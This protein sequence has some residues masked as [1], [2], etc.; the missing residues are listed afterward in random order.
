MLAYAG[1]ISM[2]D[3]H[4]SYRRNFLGTGHGGLIKA[5]QQPRKNG[6]RLNL[7]HMFMVMMLVIVTLMTIKSSSLI[8]EGTV[9]PLP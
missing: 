7:I 2:R 4:G 9:D 5:I 3:Y 1:R 8:D 6:S